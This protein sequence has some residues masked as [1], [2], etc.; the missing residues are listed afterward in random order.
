METKQAMTKLSRF[1]TWLCVAGWSGA[2]F[3][4]I[5]C[6]HLS[7]DRYFRDYDDAYSDFA[8]GWSFVKRKVDVSDEEWRIWIPLMFQLVPWIALQVFVS[9]C[10]KILCH[11]KTLLCSWYAALSVIFLWNYFGLLSTLCTLL[12]PCI[13]CLL[14]SLRSKVISWIV[15]TATLALIYY[16]KVSDV[17]FR[18]WLMLEDEE[19][20]M[21][22]AAICWIQLRS[23]SYS[24]DSIE[25]YKHVDVWGFV[26]DLLQNLAYCLYLP[27][28]FLGPV[29]F[30]QQFLDGVNKPFTQWG[31]EKSLRIFSSLVRYTFWM[32]FTQLA[33]HYVYFNAL[34]FH[35]EFVISL[36]PW[37]FYGLGYCMG[38]YFLNKYVVVYGLT[39]TVCRAEDIDA[40]PQPKCI[41]RIHLYS[42]MWKHF[43][44]GLYKFLLRYIYIPCNPKSAI[45]KFFASAV[46]FT[47]I[48]LWH[49]MH[50]YIFIWAFLNFF[51]LFIETIAKSISGFFYQNIIRISISPQNK[52]RLECMISSPLLALSAISNFYFFAGDEI[53]H[54]YI[55]RVFR[56][57]WTATATLLLALYCCCQTS[58]EVKQFEKGKV[59]N[60]S[61]DKNKIL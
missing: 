57:S 3:Y 42:D 47:F 13:S 23:I 10:L 37:A 52:R 24:I 7:T 40:P 56:E 41:G 48:Y 21:L 19:Y 43:D 46:C 38:Q 2:V 6:V 44:R 51:G 9:Q 58:T 53:G 25:S 28:L 60:E 36:R 45:G 55:Y 31:K 22:T 29:I 17:I 49:G 61:K 34:R 11:N 20:F 32:Y 54:M 50:L 18:E 5:Y 15:H 26:Q 30:Y 35:P 39:S 16:A 12:L 27:T 14:A 1:E 59:L 4:S 33:L 8:P